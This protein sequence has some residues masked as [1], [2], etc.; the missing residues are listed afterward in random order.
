MSTALIPDDPNPFGPKLTF[1]ERCAIYAMFHYKNIGH[2]RLS[3]A[4]NIHIKTVG[5][6]CSSTARSYKNVHSENLKLGLQ[7]MWDTYVTEELIKRVNQAK[8]PRDGTG[9]TE[10]SKAHNAGADE[11]HSCKYGE[12][13]A[14]W[15]ANNDVEGWFAEFRNPEQNFLG[16]DARS[17]PFLTATACIKFWNNSLNEDL[18]T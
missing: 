17:Y 14:I 6:I 11:W 18:L 8:S 4:F 16:S 1:A 5:F 15:T 2:T 12:F 3:R 7:G 10:P 13:R 9:L